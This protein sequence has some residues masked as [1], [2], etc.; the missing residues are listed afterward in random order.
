MA[1][2]WKQGELSIVSH[3]WTSCTDSKFCFCMRWLRWMYLYRAFQQNTDGRPLKRQDIHWIGPIH[4][5]IV[6]GRTTSWFGR[7]IKPSTLLPRCAGLTNDIFGGMLRTN[8]CAYVEA[9]I[10]DLSQRAG[11][12]TTILCL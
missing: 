5:T 9:C 4:A 6:D 10:M 2:D 11:Y 12:H 8:Q 3:Q 1:V 7:T